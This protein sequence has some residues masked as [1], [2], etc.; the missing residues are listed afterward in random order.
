MHSKI[1]LKEELNNKETMSFIGVYDVFSATIAARYYD[2][3]FLSGY[4]FAASYYGLPDIGFIS[5]SDMVAYAQRVKTMLPNKMLLVDID[6]G[7]CD[8]EVACHVASLLETAGVSGI[9]LEDQMRPRRCGH[10]EGKQLLDLDSYLNKLDRVL[11]VTGKMAVVA[12]TDAS[13]PIEIAK[14]VEAFT[15]LRPDAIL[16]D[17]VKDLDLVKWVR[18]LTDCPLVFNQIAGG[19]SPIYSRT[20]LEDVG[21]TIVLYSTPCLFAA[22]AAI[23]NT[24]RSIKETNGMMDKN[25]RFSA[26]LKSCSTLL[27]EN[28]A[29]RDVNLAICAD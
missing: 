14:R 3:I 4:S 7:Y 6:D 10:F 2:G 19:K 22:Q 26:D 9:I 8:T 24:L 1:D 23:E 17:G 15:S 11:A 27:Q 16:V 18:Q 13:D 28:L 20:Q 29:G 12:R 5:W 25:A 21:V